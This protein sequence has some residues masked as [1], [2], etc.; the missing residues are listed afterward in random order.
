MR[1]NTKKWDRVIRKTRQ[2]IKEAQK[3]HAKRTSKHVYHKGY[4][5]ND[6]VI[7]KNH[8]KTGGKL[9]NYYQGPYVVVGQTGPVTYKIREAAKAG[10]KEE[11]RHYN[12]LLPWRRQTL[13]HEVRREDDEVDSVIPEVQAEINPARRSTRTRRPTQFIQ[14]QENQQSYQYSEPVAYQE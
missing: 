5:L 8:Q 14:L 2:R 9:R 13:H 4:Q 1:E 10:A 6:L 7:K 12:E 11:S 3:K